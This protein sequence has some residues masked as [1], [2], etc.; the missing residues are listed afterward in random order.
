MSTSNAQAGSKAYAAFIPELWSTKIVELLHK[1]C[2]MLQCVNRN[3]E[4]EIR[5]K[6]DT[7]HIR[8]FSAMAITDYDG[9]IEDAAYETPTPVEQ[10]LVIDQAKMWGLKI[11]DVSKAQSDIN[12]LTGYAKEAAYA[13]ETTID[14]FLLA[15]HSDVPAGNT[16]GTVTTPIALT[17]DNIYSYMVDLAAKLEDA[18]AVGEGMKKPFVVINPKIKALVLKSPE[19]IHATALGDNVLRKGAIGEIAGMDVLVST[20]FVAVSSKY[21]ILAGTNEAITFAEQLTKTETVKDKSFFGDLV[22]GLAVY[23]A[24]TVQANALAKIIATVA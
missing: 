4:G 16:I 13:L 6:G 23:G 8:S 18:N 9:S 21:Y 10:E 1:N 2:V 11:D 24:K 20:N 5:Q 17:K 3:Y 14:T 22:R 7:V 12:I 19:F 15:K